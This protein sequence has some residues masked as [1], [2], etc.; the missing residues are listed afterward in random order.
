PDHLSYQEAAT[1]PCAA[2]TAWHALVESGN[3]KAA[4]T[5]LLLGTGGVSIFAL[6]FARMHGA[7]VIQ[8]SS[9]DEKLER[10]RQL[11]AT[12][13]I[14]YRTSEAWDRAA[15]SLTAN[16][17]VDH[18]VE[19]GGAGTLPR[20][21]NAVRVGGHIALIGNLAAGSAIDPIRVFMKA[22][23]LQGV[24]VGSRHMFED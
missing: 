3:L 18:V 19:V 11:G 21:L 22:I 15:H 6:Q 8:T 2:V 17:G 12:D 1:L 24:Y 5:V 9:S 4:D 14:N 10:V 16:L 23:R 7:R 20:S 13:T